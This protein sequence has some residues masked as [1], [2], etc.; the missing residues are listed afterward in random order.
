MKHLL[1]LIILFLASCSTDVLD[2]PVNPEDFQAVKVKINDNSNYSQEKK[3]YLLKHI[4]LQTGFGG[5]AKAPTFRESIQEL[6]SY[7]DSALALN[8]TLDNFIELRGAHTVPTDKYKGFLN[9]TV[10]FN[11]GFEQEIHYIIVDYRYVNEYDTEFFSKR[12]KI[13]SKVAKKF[14][15]TAELGVEGKYDRLAEFINKN[16][17]NDEL[18]KGLQI[19]TKAIFF[20]D[21]SKL[22]KVKL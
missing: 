14:Y 20:T 3:D 7:Y 12:S 9:F 1:I 2:K 19:E 17:S 5:L 6:S 10:K 11:H 4:K 8:H 21:G 13:T 15:D 18:L 22:E 16:I